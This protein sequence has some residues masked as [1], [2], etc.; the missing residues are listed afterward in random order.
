M[1]KELQGL[2][3][4]VRQ[5]VEHY[6][7]IDDGDRIAV[8]LSGGKD[9]GAL[10]LALAKMR[11]FY[12]KKYEIC[13]ITVDMGFEGGMDSLEPLLAFCKD[14]DVEL[15]VVKTEIA[16]IVFKERKEKNPCSLCA[17]MRRGA[18]NGEA[19]R[20]RANKIALGHHL[21]D[22]VE[23]MMMSLIHE[24]RIGSFM[25]VT[26][27]DNTG[28]SVIR[29]LIYTREADIKGVVRAENIPVV[30]SLCPENGET[31]RAHAKDLLKS[32]EKEHRGVYRRLIGALEKQ[33]LDGW[34]P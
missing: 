18:L 28:I 10:M 26:V 29:P 14:I 6:K 7:M 11:D 15:Y 12:P 34:H 31:E 23:T 30:A 25:P 21:E 8:G 4:T 32:L 33:E 22:A 1:A 16:E 17:K 5:A 27:Y 9:S 2:L 13:A 19:L 24:G 20:L 3:S